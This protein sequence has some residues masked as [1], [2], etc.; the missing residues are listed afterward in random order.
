MLL[1]HIRYFLAVAEQGNFTRAAESLHVSQPT[2]SQQI[3]QLE[4][5]LGTPLFDR[6]GRTVRLTDAGMAWM[7]YARLALQ[8]L[9]AGTRAIHDVATLERGNLRLAMTPT[10]TAYLVGPVIDAFYRQ[11]PGV[12]V[13][14]HEM[15]Q[16]R[17]E[18]LLAEDRLDVG[19]AFSQ[20]QSVDIVAE[21][22]FTESLNMMVGAQ[23]PLVQQREPLSA[24]VFEQQPLVLLSEDFATRQFIDDYC[25][26]QGIRPR[27]AMEANAIGAI[28]EIVRRGQLTTLLP[29]AVAQEN[30]QLHPVRLTDVMPAR[31]AV[32]L[33]RKDAY[34]SA[35]SRAFIE[36]LHRQKFS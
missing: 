35:A 29:A 28:I 9:E 22:L 33:Q 6:S 5:Y 19:I 1:R 8:D 7:R 13:S 15:T 12:S 20:A 24:Q 18:A 25:R 27:V 36:V 3:K 4:E 23:H 31:R 26:R 32:L 34:R 30:L 14:I 2:L 10:F 11:Y 21:E 16:D 17:I